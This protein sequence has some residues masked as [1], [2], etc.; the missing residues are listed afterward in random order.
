MTARAL[1]KLEA[2]MSATDSLLC[3]GLDSAHGRLPGRFVLYAGLEASKAEEVER[4][5]RLE[6]DRVVSK[7]LR[8]DEFERARKQIISAHEM[9]LQ[10]S[11]SV[12]LDCVL[13]ELYGL[14]YAHSSGTRARLAVLTAED[15]RK[16]AAS[17]I[18]PDRRSLVLVLP[19]TKE[20]DTTE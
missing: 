10:D 9:S 4:L 15:V 5:A 6:L 19:G 17:L 16:A 14:G 11:S 12:A 1:A 2:R 13:N 7:G 20:E 8:Q 3:V 18:R